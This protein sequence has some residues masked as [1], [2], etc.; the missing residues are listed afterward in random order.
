[1]DNDTHIY[2]YISKLY[3]PVDS[4]LANKWS[5]P[6]TGGQLAHRIVQLRFI[7]ADL[8]KGRRQGMQL[9]RLERQNQWDV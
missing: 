4:Q 9:G 2:I 5:G 7:K 8:R 1:M 6:P 3:D